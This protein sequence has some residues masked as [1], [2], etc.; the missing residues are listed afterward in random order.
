MYLGLTVTL[1][2]IVVIPFIGESSVRYLY[3]RTRYGWEVEEYSLYSTIDVALA[4][5]GESI[6]HD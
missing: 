5:V 3:V 6:N 2:I 4:A 1:F